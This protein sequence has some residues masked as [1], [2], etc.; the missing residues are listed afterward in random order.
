MTM[1]IK[2]NLA[3][4]DETRSV[5][6]GV[7]QVLDL[8]DVQATRSVL[9]PGWSWSNSIKPIA[10]TD[11]CQIPHVIYVVAGRMGVR[12]DDGSEAELLAGDVA[13]IPPG[14]DAWVVGDEPVVGIDFGGGASLGKPPTPP[15]TP[16]A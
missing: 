9:Q 6:N 3:V 16:T 1:L 5:P 8:G 12:M 11:S 7:I 13:V 14:H 2:K 4:P 10:K 15:A